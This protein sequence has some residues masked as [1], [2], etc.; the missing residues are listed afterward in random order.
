MTFVN[1]CLIDKMLIDNKCILRISSIN[2]ALIYKI[3]LEENNF[4]IVLS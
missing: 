2:F 1:I 4:L 3:V